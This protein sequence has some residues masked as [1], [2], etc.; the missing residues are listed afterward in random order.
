MMARR[1]VSLSPPLREGCH[2]HP[3]GPSSMKTKPAT[4]TAT[5]P[6][7]SRAGLAQTGDVRN[8]VADVDGMC[9]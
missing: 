6:V 9:E 2:R 5:T 8:S 4:R 3:A 7:N 1:C